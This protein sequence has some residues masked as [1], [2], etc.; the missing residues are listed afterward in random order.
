MDV[1][2]LLE[3]RARRMAQAHDHE[4]GALH[5]GYHKD[6]FVAHCTR[7]GALLIVSLHPERAGIRGSACTVDCRTRR[8]VRLLGTTTSRPPAPGER[9]DEEY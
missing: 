3:E 4:I 6:E 9:C 2:T 1:R 7:C 5:T 8:A